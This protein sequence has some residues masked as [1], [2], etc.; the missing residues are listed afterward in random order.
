MAIVV[1]SQKIDLLCKLLGTPSVDRRGVNAQFWCPMCNDSDRKKRKLA[2]RIEDGV[3]HCWV[4][5]WSARNVAVLAK[6]LGASE[7]VQPL[8]EAYGAPA[9]KPEG[10]DEADEKFKVTLPEDYQPITAT[11][12]SRDP[13]REAC[14][15]YLATRGVSLQA[16]QAFRLGTSSSGAYRRRV[17]F[18]SFDELGELN[19][20]TARSTSNEF[21][22][23]YLNTACD[24]K[25]IVFNEVDVDW[26][27][28]LVVVEGPFDLLSCYNMNATAA[29]GSWLDE[30]YKLFE[31][32]VVNETPVVLAF[33]PDAIVKQ[34]K[35][36]AKLS[37]YNVSVRCV[38]WPPSS[39]DV[40]PSSVGH[41]AFVKLVKEALP[42]S[43]AKHYL[44]K[45]GRALDSTRLR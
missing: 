35:V 18:P 7:L 39:E 1:A 26:K 31:R 12:T 38:E 5:G 8:V 37:S 14:V 43:S 23:K 20:V 3:A 4:C 22:P 11:A 16:A 44:A 34:E 10:A 41:A 28:E 29:L 45:L 36:A 21:K 24:R 42:Y 17:V 2:V 33:D 25:S 9:F 15:R 19:Y 27:K 30:N 13:S 6:L 32:I 40:D